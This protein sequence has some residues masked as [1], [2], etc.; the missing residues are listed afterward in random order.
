MP[1]KVTHIGNDSYGK[2]P[3]NS[4]N[5]QIIMEFKHLYPLLSRYLPAALNSHE[6]FKEFLLT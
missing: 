5:D 6:N 2:M 4:K 3:K 1:C